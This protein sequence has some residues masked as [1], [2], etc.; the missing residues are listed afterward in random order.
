VKERKKQGER[1]GEER[2]G[3]ERRG[4]RACENCEAQGPQASPS[5]NSYLCQAQE[6]LWSG[7][8]VGSFNHWFVRDACCNFV[9]SI[10]PIFITFGT[11][12][13]YLCQMSLLT[14]VRSRSKFK[15]KPNYWKSPNS[16]SSG[17][18]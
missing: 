3:E 12:V 9:K 2:R 10:N 7:E 16:N 11:D 8:S 13:Q 18:V 5:F 4:G 6:V 17:V 15:V 14:F 1:G